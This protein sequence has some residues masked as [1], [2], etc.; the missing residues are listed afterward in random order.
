MKKL[1][2]S[3]IS[4]VINGKAIVKNL[5]FSIDLGDIVGFLGPNG[6]SS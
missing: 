2:L 1:E 6:R 5:S 3:N 4:K